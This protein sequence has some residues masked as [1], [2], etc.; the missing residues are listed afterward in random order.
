MLSLLM[1]RWS[2]SLSVPD[3]DVPALRGAAHDGVRFEDVD[4]L[5]GVEVVIRAEGGDREAAV[6]SACSAYA[7]L[8]KGAGL[9]EGTTRVV[10]LLPDGEEERVAELMAEARDLHA[11]GHHGWAIAAAQTAC[12]LRGRAVLAVLAGRHGELGDVAERF[13]GGANPANDR[14][15][16]ALHALSGRDPG[17]EPWWGDYLAH[18]QRRN[19][20]VH[21]GAQTTEHDAERSLEACTSLLAFLDALGTAAR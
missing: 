11:A 18:A 13:A 1:A 12:E 6:R 14:V 15:R 10:A 16:R 7:G 21:E 8:R 20:L 9:D 4:G 5:S 17:T 19:R 2:V 3:E